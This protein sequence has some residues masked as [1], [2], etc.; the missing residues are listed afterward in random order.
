MET[1]LQDLRYAGRTLLKRP[2]FTA[3]A[4]L[5]LA[6]GIGA[7]T[8][9]FSVVDSVLLAPLPFRSAERLTMIWASN[10]DLARQV[11]LPDKLPVSPAT[12]YDWKTAKSFEKMAIVNAD[13]L[14]LTGDGDPLQLAAVKV[15]GELFQALGTPALLGRPLMPE[16]DDGGKRTTILLSHEFWRRHFGGDRNVIGRVLHVDG[17][18]LT[19]VG[20]MP[21]GFAFPRG[22]EMPHGFGFAAQPSTSRTRRGRSSTPILPAWRSSASPRSRSCGATGPRTSSPIPDSGPGSWSC[23]RAAG[24]RG[25]S[26]SPSG[27]RTGRSGRSSTAATR[28]ATR[29]PARSSTTAS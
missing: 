25:R 26:S 28:C 20:V 5:T 2:A 8:A 22:G 1:L 17:A 6:L 23:W 3:I 15:S 9:I 4:V 16:D 12:F 29:R 14:S 13:R 19:V 7:N 24:R 18:P 11:G 10:P 21:A 27:A